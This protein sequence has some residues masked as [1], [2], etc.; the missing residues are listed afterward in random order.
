LFKTQ[1]VYGNPYVMKK[2]DAAMKAGG[3]QRS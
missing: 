2:G 1:K 3:A